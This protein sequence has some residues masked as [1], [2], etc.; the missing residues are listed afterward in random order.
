MGVKCGLHTQGQVSEAAHT[1]PLYSRYE[2]THSDMQSSCS[3]TPR[4]SREIMTSLHTID[5]GRESKR[6]E[7]SSIVLKPLRIRDDHESFSRTG[8][9]S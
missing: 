2:S 3:T 9:E 7:I 4:K 8:D 1:R 5:R 6:K